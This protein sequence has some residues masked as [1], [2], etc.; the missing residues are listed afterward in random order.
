[1]RDKSYINIEKNYEEYIEKIDEFEN[2]IFVDVYKNLY[3]ILN[4]AVLE[5]DKKRGCI[6]TVLGKRG[7]G[8][9]SLLLSFVN[10]LGDAS[11]G[12]DSKYKTDKAQFSIMKCLDA[13][14]LDSSEDVFDI[15]LSR[16]LKNIEQYIEDGKFDVLQ[17]RKVQY[18]ILQQIDEIYKIHQMIKLGKAR[19]KDVELSDGFSSFSALR[20]CPDSLELTSK[21]EKLVKNYLEMML[22]KKWNEG[23]KKQNNYLI[24]PIDDLDMNNDKGFESLEQLYR[25]VAVKNVIVVVAVKYEQIMYLAEKNGYGLFPKIDRKLSKSKVKYV[26]EYA[27]EYLAKLLPIQGRVYMPDI[28]TNQQEIRKKWYVRRGEGGY[29]IKESL[30]FMIKEKTGMYFDICGKKMHFLEPESL[31]ELKGYYGYLNDKLENDR[32]ENCEQFVSDFLNRITNK[33]LTY[34]DRKEV[35]FLCELDYAGINN[36]L[37]LKLSKNELCKTSRHKFKEGYGELLRYLYLTSRKKQEDKQ[38]AYAVL[39]FYTYLA[40][41]ERLKTE[42]GTEQSDKKSDMRELFINSWAGSWSNDLVPKVHEDNIGDEE[43]IKNLFALREKMWGCMEDIDA[44]VAR[45]GIEWEDCMVGIPEVW[46]DENREKIE[47]LEWMFFFFEEFYSD[48][49]EKEEIWLEMEQKADGRLECTIANAKCDFNILAFIK[50]SYYYEEY[51]DG[52]YTAIAEALIGHSEGG[53]ARVT[54]MIERLKKNSK[55]YKAYK[56][57]AKT[58]EGIAMPFQYTD[59]YYHILHRAQ[60][61]SRDQTR[62]AVTCGEV[63]SVLSTLYHRLKTILSDEDEGYK[64]IGGTNFAENFAK[65]PF[66][67]VLLGSVKKRIKI[68]RIS[69]GKMVNRCASYSKSSRRTMREVED[70]TTSDQVGFDTYDW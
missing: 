29:T 27:K 34:S 40:Q 25:Y 54:K 13:S 3:K 15:L 38:F 16:M 6:I 8:K 43:N 33:K 70:L 18:E 48:M 5:K 20:N 22:G 24:V 9:S 39:V 1:M 19:G 50:H 26:K 37:L 65:C 42:K 35:L 2:S 21:F 63:F 56:E 61:Q 28:V 49:Y 41:R 23:A 11:G 12:E 52:L 66:I 17:N 31:R 4:A 51:F 59:I 44:S 62:A 67:E 32:L 69:F 30:F 36:R 45:I 60:N 53:W 14:M 55:L 68:D 10:S 58:S 46:I 57:W 7:S 64:E 47:Q